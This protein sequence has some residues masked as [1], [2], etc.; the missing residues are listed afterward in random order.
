MSKRT[1]L[2]WATGF[3]EGEGG[4]YVR[5]TGACTLRV[6]Q[7]T[8]ERLIR[9]CNAVGAGVVRGP[10]RNGTRLDGSPIYQYQAIVR[11]RRIVGQVL[12]A[13]WPYMSTQGK[14]QTKVKWTI[15][16]EKKKVI[17]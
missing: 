14:V 15:D 11:S 10:Y 17:R 8:P 5:A 3:Y 16:S 6:T 2:A 1:E 13:M 7:S 9:F 4:F 12:T